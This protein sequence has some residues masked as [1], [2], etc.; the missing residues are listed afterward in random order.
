MRAG[1]IGRYT[2]RR[3][4]KTTRCGGQLALH[5]QGKDEI[6]VEDETGYI[7]KIKL[8]KKKYQQRLA[9]LGTHTSN[10]LAYAASEDTEVKRGGDSSFQGRNFHVDDSE[11]I[12]SFNQKMFVIGK[13][14]DILDIYRSNQSG[15]VVKK[16]RPAK[17]VDV[18]PPNIT[19]KFDGWDEKHNVTLNAVKHSSRIKPFRKKLFPW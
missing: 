12:S 17:I 9:A 13:Q 3:V 15:E 14:F 7:Q 8:N 19:V 11:E 5:G 18:E 4:R 16:W 2:N 6:V 10:A 1:D